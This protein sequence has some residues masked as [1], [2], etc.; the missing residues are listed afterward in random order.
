MN[1]TFPE[2]LSELRTENGWTQQQLGIKLNVS[3]ATVSRYE[4]GYRRPD[5]EILLKLADIFNVSVD[6]LL[7]RVDHRLYGMKSEKLPNPLNNLSTAE[8]RS[9]EDYIE[10]IRGK[11]K[12]K[13]GK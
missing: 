1:Y 3:V 7:G 9:V 12:K 11:A 6:Y 2:R 10:F 8:R 5:P 4:N 13:K